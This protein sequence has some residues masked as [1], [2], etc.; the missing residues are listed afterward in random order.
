M[1]SAFVGLI[2]SVF[3]SGRVVPGVPTG[4]QE[5]VES[6]GAT[7]VSM[8]AQGTGRIQMTAFQSGAVDA[9][10]R[11]LPPPPPHSVSNWTSGPPPDWPSPH[12]HDSHTPSSYVHKEVTELMHMPAAL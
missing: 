8:N 5:A 10:A 1:D 7:M 11:P 12:T 6:E 3:N 4:T 9:Q 2:F